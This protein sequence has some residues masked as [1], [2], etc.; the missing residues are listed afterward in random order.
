M[1][2]PLCP[3]G[4]PDRRPHELQDARPLRAQAAG[5]EMRLWLAAT[6]APGRSNGTPALAAQVT[7][8][9]LRATAAE[10]RVTGKTLGGKKQLFERRANHG[11]R[12][13]PRHA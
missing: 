12:D 10:Q 2:R 11:A 4:E 8:D 7:H 13:S 9:A 1:D 5:A 6:F 3:F